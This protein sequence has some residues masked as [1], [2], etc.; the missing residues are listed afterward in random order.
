MVSGPAV[1]PRLRDGR[2]PKNKDQRKFIEECQDA[3]RTKIY[4]D[5]KMSIKS[6]HEQIKMAKDMPSN[7]VYGYQEAATHDMKGII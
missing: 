2:L 6:A 7:Y 1:N 4:L 3:N 5:K